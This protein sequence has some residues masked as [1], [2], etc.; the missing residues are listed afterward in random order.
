MI[1]ICSIHLDPETDTILVRM[2]AELTDEAVSAIAASVLTTAISK[3]IDVIDIMNA[4]A[5]C[6]LLEVHEPRV[7]SAFPKEHMN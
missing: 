2:D 1:P 3:G 4:V 5:N 6:Q 7:K